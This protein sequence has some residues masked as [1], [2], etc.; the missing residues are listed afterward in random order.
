MGVS[1]SV[2]MDKISAYAKTSEGQKRMQN[3]IQSYING[4]DPHVKSTGKTYGGGKI[5]NNQ[6][7]IEAAKDFI[8]MLKRAAASAGLPNSVMEHV[9]SFMFTA[10]FIASD[11]SASIQIYMSD[12]PHRPSLYPQKYD[13]VDNIVAIFNSGYNAKS[14]VY[15]K[16]HDKYV[17]SLDK[18]QGAFF[19][20]DAVAEFI[21]KYSSDFD[22]SIEVSPAYGDI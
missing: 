15:G 14:K 10:P 3:K 8:A 12:D 13:G 11:G 18:R 21:S 4:S 5:M 22:V 6:Q 2:I 7:M 1:A 9:E 20:Q 17:S 16:W 19:I